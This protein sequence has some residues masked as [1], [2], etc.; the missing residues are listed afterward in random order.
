MF[1][2]KIILITEFLSILYNDMYINYIISKN[3][4]PINLLPINLHMNL[5]GGNQ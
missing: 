4:L 2:K 5:S 1:F 3:I